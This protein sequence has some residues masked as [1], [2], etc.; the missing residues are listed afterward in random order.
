LKLVGRLLDW[1]GRWPPLVPAVSSVLKTRV[2]LQLENIALRH[3]I[4]VLQRSA[5]KRP[6]LSA[7]D[8]RLW[9]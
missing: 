2:A 5:N 7:T 4:A 6:N 1:N 8:R 3:Q 9:V